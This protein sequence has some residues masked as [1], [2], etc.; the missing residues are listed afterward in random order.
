MNTIPDFTE[1]EQQLISQI[2][3][4][5]YTRLV[6]WQL[7]EAELQLDPES[8]ELTACPTLYWSQR[9]AEFIVCK[10]GESRFRCQFFYSEKEQFGT[11][12]EIYDDFGDCVLTL[13]QVQADHERTRSGAHQGVGAAKPDEEEYLGPTLI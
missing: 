3:F 9:G 2:L 1:A 7:A 6:P 11:G 13:L 12:R 4:E 8:E 10:L 5:R